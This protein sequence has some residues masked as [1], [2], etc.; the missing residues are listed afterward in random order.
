MV[1]KA[2]EACREER[3]EGEQD[4]EQP[5]GGEQ[6]SESR[7]ERE[8]G[9]PPGGTHM[10]GINYLP[11]MYNKETHFNYRKSTKSTQ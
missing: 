3:K 9:S 1:L 6:E 10:T 11:F 7:G 4:T 5:M 8:R 2:M